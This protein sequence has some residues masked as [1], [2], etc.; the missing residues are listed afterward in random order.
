M[1]FNGP[2]RRIYIEIEKSLKQNLL[3][4]QLHKFSQL[5]TK[6]S[7]ACGWQYAVG[8]DTHRWW[9]YTALEIEL[10][11]GLKLRLNIQENNVDFIER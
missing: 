2:V 7:E 1:P 5:T 3:I 6:D 8:D 11:H 4:S 10:T 9:S